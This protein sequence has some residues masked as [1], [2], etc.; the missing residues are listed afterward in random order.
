MKNRHLWEEWK[1]K[2][3][4]E[5]GTIEQIFDDGTIFYKLKGVKGELAETTYVVEPDKD[6]KKPW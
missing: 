6:M 2:K 3:I 5:I 4:E 1:L